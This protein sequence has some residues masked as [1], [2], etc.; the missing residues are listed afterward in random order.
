MSLNLN[1]TTPL[2]YLHKIACSNAEDTRTDI[3]DDIHHFQKALLNLGSWLDRVARL[4]NAPINNP[5]L[6]QIARIYQTRDLNGKTSSDFVESVTRLLTDEAF[7]PVDDF[8]IANLQA[9]ELL[10]EEYES[11]SRIEN[12]IHGLIKF[13]ASRLTTKPTLNSMID[14]SRAEIFNQSLELIRSEVDAYA[15]GEKREYWMMRQ[16]LETLYVA[17][18]EHDIWNLLKIA[19]K[20]YEKS[21]HVSNYQDELDYQRTFIELP[22]LALESVANIAIRYLGD[23]NIS[24]KVESSAIQAAQKTVH[25][26]QEKIYQVIFSTGDEVRDGSHNERLLTRIGNIVRDYN[27]TKIPSSL[28]DCIKQSKCHGSN[29]DKLKAIEALGFVCGSSLTRQDNFTCPIDQFL[30]LTRDWIENKDKRPGETMESAS[31]AALGRIGGNKALELIKQYY[32]NYRA[33]PIEFFIA[34]RKIGKP[35]LN[36]LITIVDGD[37]HL[38]K[39]NRDCMA[40]ITKTLAEIGSHDA[41]KLLEKIYWKLATDCR[42]YLA[43]GAFHL[44]HSHEGAEMMGRVFDRQ[45]LKCKSGTQYDKSQLIDLAGDIAKANLNFDSSSNTY[46][47]IFNKVRVCLREAFDE[48][49]SNRCD[50]YALANATRSLWYVAN[51]D[52][53]Q[54]LFAIGNKHSYGQLVGETLRRADDPSLIPALARYLEARNDHRDS[55]HEIA[56]TLAAQESPDLVTLLRDRLGQ[57]QARWRTI[58]IAS[59][60]VKTYTSKYPIAAC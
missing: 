16:A 31:L 37:F 18:S 22:L 17:G 50:Y 19:N 52:D 45:S 12:S 34:L 21:F 30:D 44:I 41:V 59:A 27:L 28:I 8:N 14:S 47:S 36:D 6:S 56:S 15:K 2:G 39:H 58:D 7:V 35:A 9:L 53:F 49:L 13:K 32:M 57:E 51:T 10:V 54:A 20:L 23:G 25:A 40:E 60:I 38:L 33:M 48:L 5:S 43:S 24:K 55:I 46:P 11:L 42:Q 3:G 26:L 29:M 1:I 4:T